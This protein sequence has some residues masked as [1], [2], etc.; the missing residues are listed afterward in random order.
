MQTIKTAIS[1]QRPLFEQA[2]SLAERLEISRSRL[3]I[4]AYLPVF[5]ARQNCASQ[6]NW[7]PLP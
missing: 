7:R 3:F 6:S 2:E 4:I 5:F 1:L